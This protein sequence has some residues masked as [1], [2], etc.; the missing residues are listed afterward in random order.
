[1]AIA[2][3][4]LFSLWPSGGLFTVAVAYISPY[5]Q[6]MRTSVCLCEVAFSCFHFYALGYWVYLP[7][8]R[9]VCATYI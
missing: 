8:V 3:R 1:M 5:V 7:S 4:H 2:N 6:S 9:E